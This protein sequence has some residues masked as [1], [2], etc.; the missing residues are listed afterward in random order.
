MNFGFQSGITNIYENGL[1]YKGTWNATLNI[2][3]LTS[4][5]GVSGEYYVVSVAG[6]TNLDGITDWQVGDWA[7]FVTDSPDRWQKVDNHD[8]QA[9]TTIQDEGANLPQRSILD[10]QGTG[11]TAT[12]L[13]GKTVVTIPSYTGTAG[14]I[15]DYNGVAFPQRASLN[16]KGLGVIVTDDA[17]NNRTDVDI[18]GIGY[19]SWYDSLTQT[20]LVNTPTAMQY[21]VPD[22]A[23]G[24]SVVNDTFGKPTKITATNTGIYNVQFSAQTYRTAGGTTEKLWIWLRINGVDV[25]YSSTQITFKDNNNY[26][27]AAW[28]F[29][30]PLT[31]GS[32]CQIM[33]AVTDV[34]IQ[35]AAIVPTLVPVVPET[36][37][38]I[39]TVTRL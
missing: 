16:F 3:T 25:P 39:L 34:R 23:I 29:F 33:W 28:N 30:A 20:A 2:P 35:L 18:D 19:G 13:G 37:S 26:A 27:V 4:G 11:V 38:V 17:I 12:D 6:N 8:V 24:I 22:F 31:A 9:Y 14:H 7:I 15:I 21:N 10:F 1:T 36:P 5:V 32:N